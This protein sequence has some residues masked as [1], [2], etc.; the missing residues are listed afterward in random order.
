MQ[1]NR[2]LI[3]SILIVSTIMLLINIIMLNN[4][5]NLK[6]SLIDQSVQVTSKVNSMDSTLSNTISEIKRKNMWVNN[7]KYTIEN[8]DLDKKTANVKIEFLLNSFD[9][10]M[11]LFIV[12]ISKH[13]M[14]NK[15][16]KVNK[17]TGLNYSQTV[18]LSTNDNYE[19]QLL[20]EGENSFKSEILFSLSLKDI[21]TNLYDIKI[22]L[23][24]MK[25][26]S[27]GTTLDF[28]LIIHSDYGYKY[29]IDS[30]DLKMKDISVNICYID[31]KL[32]KINLLK[33]YNI[34]EDTAILL[35]KKSLL[36]KDIDS[37]R[38]NINET[39]NKKIE[40][41]QNIYLDIKITNKL[42]AVFNKK[43]GLLNNK[44]NIIIK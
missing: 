19:V 28:N 21:I 7:S 16:I 15:K 26:S 35:D 12:F 23:K 11:D 18:L 42:G 13:N 9:K 43:I 31:D 29:N 39:V 38:F 10:N 44:H 14:D 41:P 5:K 36:R 22:E 25:Q 20:G 37:Y 4:I 32:K 17:N 3:V 33:D 2:I 6:N 30:E 40:N 34:C 24:E 8:I 1:K 27:N